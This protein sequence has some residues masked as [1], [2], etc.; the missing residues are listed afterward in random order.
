LPRI[1]LKWMVDGALDAGLILKQDAYRKSCTLVADNALGKVHRMGRIWA[2][3][4][5]RHRRVPATARV[6]Q[7]V[8]DRISA[9]PAYRSKVPNTTVWDDV[10]WLTPKL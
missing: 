8:Q 10:A 2:L 9:E 6:H 1:T 5:Y 4:T 7:S 3:L